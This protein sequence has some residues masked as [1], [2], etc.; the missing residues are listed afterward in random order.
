M[1]IQ[2]DH[3]TTCHNMSHA[4]TPVHPDVTRK[5]TLVCDINDFM[6]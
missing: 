3:V 4:C 1:S 2:I 5:V 6:L